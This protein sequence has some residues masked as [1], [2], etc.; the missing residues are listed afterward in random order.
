MWPT[1]QFHERV[2]GYGITH[3]RPHFFSD[4]DTAH[5]LEFFDCEARIACQDDQFMSQK[6]LLNDPAATKVETCP[7]STHGIVESG[8]PHR[9]PESLCYSEEPV[10]VVETLAAVL[11]TMRIWQRWQ[12]CIKCREPLLTQ[13]CALVL[14]TKPNNH[15]LYLTVHFG[16]EPYLKRL[17]GIV[18]LVDAQLIDP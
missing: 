9:P 5:V 16:H 17:F 4:W 11:R 8:S 7:E 2:I 15:P 12:Q 10:C 3:Q 13:R 6:I 1:L 14:G 18:G